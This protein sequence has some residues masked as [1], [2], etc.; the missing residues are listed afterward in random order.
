LDIAVQ[1]TPP[2]KIKTVYAQDPVFNTLDRQLLASLGIRVVQDPDAFALV[3]RQTFLYSPGAERSHLM[4]MLPSSPALFFGGPIEGECSTK[5]HTD[6]R[7]RY[8]QRSTQLQTVQ[9]FGDGRE[10]EILTEFVQTTQSVPLPLFEPNE[11][12]F[13]KMRMYWKANNA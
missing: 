7:P 10:E 6:K 8:Q 1:L 2:V 5:P 11:H 9:D 4:K 13:W 12:A 3:D